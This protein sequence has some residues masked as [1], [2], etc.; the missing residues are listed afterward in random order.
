MYYFRQGHLPLEEDRESYQTD[1]LTSADQ[2]ILDQ[3]VNMPLLGEAKTAIWLVINF[4]F[5]YVAYQKL[6]YFVVF[7]IFLT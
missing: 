2:E 3:L 1:Y 5:G 7:Y 4:W 6:L